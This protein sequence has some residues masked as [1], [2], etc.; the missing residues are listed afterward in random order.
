MRKT[1]FILM[2]AFAM[3]ACNSAKNNT[4]KT[5]NEQTKETTKMGGKKDKHGCL[6]SAGET[7]SQLKQNCIQIFSVGQRLNPIETKDGEAVISAFVLFNDDKSEVELFL[8][9]TESTSILKTKNKE[10]YEN[11]A[12]KYDAKDS[13]LYVN[14]T[15]TYSADKTK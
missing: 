3:T 4:S 9:S 13:S 10:V 6:A 8:P 14:G 15:K 1:V 2:S 11:G 7:W 12:Y 5:N